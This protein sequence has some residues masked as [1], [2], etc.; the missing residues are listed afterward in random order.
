MDV[1]TRSRKDPRVKVQ[2]SRNDVI[3]CVHVLGSR[4]VTI[5]GDSTSK[6]LVPF[7]LF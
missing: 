5:I 7:G 3:A 4:T 1:E 6:A 2:T